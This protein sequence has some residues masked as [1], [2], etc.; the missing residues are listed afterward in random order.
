MIYLKIPFFQIGF[1][2]ILLFHI[3][4]ISSC[5]SHLVYTS[6]HLSVLHLHLRY[7]FLPP[8]SRFF[9][10]SVTALSLRSDEHSRGWWECL[11]SCRY[12]AINHHQSTGDIETWPD[13]G[14]RA[15]LIWPMMCV[16]IQCCESFCLCVFT[17]QTPTFSFKNSSQS[18]MLKQPSG[19]QTVAAAYAK[20]KHKSNQ[21]R[22][23][24]P[25]YVPLHMFTITICLLRR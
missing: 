13:D 21:T 9:P 2:L 1:S 19:A 4:S 11:Q 18:H 16:D 20:W 3:K 12:L 15:S 7:F 10:C 25:A 5:S 6:R 14:A 24:N 17:P 8:F 22:P 23:I